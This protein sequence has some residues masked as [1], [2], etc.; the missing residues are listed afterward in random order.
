MEPENP[1]KMPN[2]PG[3]H[4]GGR[5]AMQLPVISWVEM[6]ITVNVYQIQPKIV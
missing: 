1:L 5:P 4:A 2:L 6:L 3:F